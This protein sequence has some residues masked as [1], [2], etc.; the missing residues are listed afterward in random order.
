MQTDVK[1]H[2]DAPGHGMGTSPFSPSTT[3]CTVPCP[4]SIFLPS[5]PFLTPSRS[6]MGTGQEMGAAGNLL[7]PHSPKAAPV[8]YR[9]ML[10]PTPPGTLICS[11][12]PVLIYG[13]G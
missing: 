6:R 5:S 13:D 10:C 7:P 8:P 4:F 9:S 12:Q 2:A 11:P 3:L 1:S